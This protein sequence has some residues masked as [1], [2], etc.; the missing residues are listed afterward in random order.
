[1]VRDGAWLRAFASS[2]TL[3]LLSSFRDAPQGAGPESITTDRDY[4]F[5]ARALRA[6]NDE[7]DVSRRSLAPCLCEQRDTLSPLVIPGCAARRRPGIHNHGLGLWIPG[8]RS[9]RPGM[10]RG[11]RRSFAPC[12]CEQRDTLSP[13]VIPGCAAR[14]R[15]G[16]H[17][18]GPGLWIPGS[19][20]ARPGMTRG[21]TWASATTTR[22]RDTLC[23]SYCMNHVLE[24][25]GAGNAGC[26]AAPAALCAK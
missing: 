12:L 13:F 20:S 6:R 11:T 2:A 22:S 10:T 23:P 19:R 14:R 17:N 26:C 1:M 18:H 8:S 15:P 21:M 3:S 7:G 25:E 4:G 5:R 9:A 16:I 24:N